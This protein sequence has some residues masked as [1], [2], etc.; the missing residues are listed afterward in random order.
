MVRVGVMIEGQENLTWDRWRSLG[1][2]VEDLGFESLWRSDHFHSLTGNYEREALETWTSLSV[3]AAETS[4]IRFGPLVCSVTFRHPS[5]IARMAAAVDR[6]SGGRLICGIGA[7]WN[8]SE[9]E[10]FGIPFPPVRDRITM[11]DEQAQILRLLWT[12]QAVSFEGSFYTLK[13]ARCLPTPAQE[14][15]PLLVGSLG[16]KRGLRITAAHADEWNAHALAL[17]DH[18]RKMEILRE[19]C[20]DLGR[21]FGMIAKSWMTGFIIGRDR[22]DVEERARG[23]QR[24]L[25]TLQA[26]DIGPMTDMLSANGWLIGTPEQIVDQIRAREAVG[27]ERVML[28]HHDHADDDAL[29]LIAAEVAPGVS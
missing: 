15:L 5:L 10:A 7:G 27:V 9:H 1:R 18:R 24:V 21:D 28:Q 17:E 26:M 4:R 14:R 23:V 3:L 29:R 22:T 11:L 20:T 2:L 13:E 19:H 12:G 6:L 16:E 25:T 8:P